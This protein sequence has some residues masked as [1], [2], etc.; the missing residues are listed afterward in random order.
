MADYAPPTQAT[1]RIELPTYNTS[2]QTW[3]VQLGAI[4]QARYITSQQSKFAYVVEKLPADVASEVA[5]ILN[6]IPPDKPYE[7]L[8]QVILQ[9]TACSEE[10]KIKE[11]TNVTLGNNKPSQLLRKM[12][13]L[14]GT[15][16]MSEAVLKQMWLDKL[17]PDTVQ[18]LATLTD[19]VFIQKL[20]AIADK[21]SD[22]R[23]THLIAS[24]ALSS[25]STPGTN[26]QLQTLASEVRK[27]SLRINEIQYIPSRSRSNS[28][29][30]NSVHRRRST[31]RRPQHQPRSVC[32]YHEVFSARAKKCQPLCS[33]PSIFAPKQ[34]GNDQPGNH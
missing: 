22:T 10:H 21:I 33:Y 31:S 6:D 25:D 27:L 18:I 20:A 28:T 32:W 16:S 2:V 9:R 30:R 1:F 7:V 23:P 11:L 12:Q 14:V 3:F 17:S 4:F 29:N 5:D 8:K 26:Q 15:N 19:E 34:Q 13:T 24:V